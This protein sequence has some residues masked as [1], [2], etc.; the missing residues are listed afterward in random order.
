MKPYCAAVGSGAYFVVKF[1]HFNVAVP[2]V[3][4]PDWK[5]KSGIECFNGSCENGKS[6]FTSDAPP[7]F[8]HFEYFPLTL[9]RNVEFVPLESIIPYAANPSPVVPSS[10]RGR[11]APPDHVSCTSPRELRYSPLQSYVAELDFIHS[12]VRPKPAIGIYMDGM[13]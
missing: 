6:R 10:T 12:A 5:I 2:D 1:P 9:I 11:L 3:N 13:R 4:C 8:V 7:D